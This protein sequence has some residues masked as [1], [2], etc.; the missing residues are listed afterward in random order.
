MLRLGRPYLTGFLPSLHWTS[1]SATFT[2]V[3]RSLIKSRMCIV[4]KDSQARIEEI[5]ETIDE[6]SGRKDRDT[7]RERLQHIDSAKKYRMSD[8]SSI[9]GPSVWRSNSEAVERRLKR[10]IVF[11]SK[12]LSEVQEVS[13]AALDGNNQELIKRLRKLFPDRPRALVGNFEGRRHWE[14]GFTD[15]KTHNRE[16]FRYIVHA[17]MGAES[18]VADALIPAE[19]RNP[20][21]GEIEKLSAYEQAKKKYTI[22]Y[23]DVFEHFRSEK[24]GVRESLFVNFFTRYLEDPSIMST[25]IISASV[26][27]QS[28]VSTYYPFGFI[29]DVPPQN[30][31]CA[32]PC[33]LG[34]T[35]RPKDDVLNEFQRVLDKASVG[36]EIRIL[37][38]EEV[39]RATGKPN[40]STGYNE[41]VVAGMSPEA[42]TVKVNGIF[43]KVDSRGCLY[44]R[45]AQT[46]PYVTPKIASLIR[47]SAQRHRLPIIAIVDDSS[48]NT[49]RG[50][51]AKEAF[52]G[53]LGL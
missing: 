52:Q 1:H 42:R 47:H 43:V 5:L 41:I 12:V 22:D 38:P 26:I 6:Y 4:S 40:G 28:H 15:P 3:Q 2:L 30:V 18:K 36:R 17:L 25:L 27:D 10:A 49:N 46:D 37:S 8:D 34:I 31:F 45:Q 53:I 11:S 39:L 19:G 32:S 20:T 14:H 9:G 16:R 51:Y 24:S 13:F 33:D 29:L 7:I 44:V 23:E 21:T 48:A 50:I 35:N